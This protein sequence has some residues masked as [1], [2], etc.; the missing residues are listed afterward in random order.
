V[1]AGFSAY[2][3]QPATYSSCVR[4][5]SEPT[6]PRRRSCDTTMGTTCS[7]SHA[8]T[9]R[10][11]TTSAL[12]VPPGYWGYLGARSNGSPRPTPASLVS[13]AARSGC[14]D[15][16]PSWH[17]PANQWHDDDR[18]NRRTNDGGGCSIFAVCKFRAGSVACSR[19]DADSRRPR[20]RQARAWG[21]SVGAV[22]GRPP[23][24]AERSYRR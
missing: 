20:C 6:G 10:T 3:W 12:P 22:P 2:D 4:R 7:L 19:W 23:S 21:P 13:A 9:A 18:T 8:Q 1:L 14:F 5:C 17:W 11:A 24:V 16:T 15:G